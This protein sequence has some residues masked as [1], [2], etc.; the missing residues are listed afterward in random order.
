M[1]NSAKRSVDPRGRISLVIP[2][3]N[4]E[5]CI[6][7]VIEKS[8]PF[9]DE[10]VVVDGHSVDRTVQVAESYGVRVV[11]DNKRGKGEAIRVGA[12][13]ATHEIVVFM[14]ADGSH[15]PEDIPHLTEPILAGH[16]DL[17]IGSRG[18][19]GSDEA[20][21]DIDKLLRMVGC[22]VILIGINMRWKT[23]FTESQNGFRAIRTEVIRALDLKENIT[24][25]EQEMMMKA[26][27]KGYVVTEVPAHEYSR[28]HGTSS[29]RLHRVWFRYIYSFIKNLF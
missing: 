18:R 9:C 7:E 2:A 16:A 13:A 10:I 27:K 19:G 23:K 4:E 26:L 1:N 11:K 22:D 20:H 21:G 8:L 15:D 3:R 12:M 29:I 17:V 25:I 28:K 5:Q 14:D 6:A 24:T